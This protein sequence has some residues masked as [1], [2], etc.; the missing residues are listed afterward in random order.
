[1][2]II[3]N[4]IEVNVTRSEVSKEE[5]AG[6]LIHGTADSALEALAHDMSRSARFL[7][8]VKLCYIDPPFNTGEKFSHYHDRLSRSD[9]LEMMRATLNQIYGALSH[10]GSLWL[11]LDDSQQ[12]WGRILLDEVFGEESFV[13]TVIW[14]KRT[15]RDNRKAFSS[16]HDYIHVYA[17]NGPKQWKAIRNGVTDPGEF[18]NPDSDPRGPWR[19]APMTVQAG[20]ATSAQF[21]TLV[22]PAGVP[23]DPPPGRCWTYTENRLTEL[24]VQGRIYWP[25][26]GAGKPRLKIYQSES[27]GL[28][29]FTIWTSA[30]VGDS[31]SAKKAL[32][33]L[34]PDIPT[35]D[36]PKPERLLERIIAI[37]SDQNDLVLDCFLGSGTTAVMAQR[38]GR[39]WVGVEQNEKTIT[40]FVI[41]RIAR[42]DGGGFE[43]ISSDDHDLTKG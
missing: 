9:W 40:N 23:H 21:Y 13:A 35:F 33:A 22:S 14:Q 16:M 3:T 1:M 12:H 27:R 34:F 31:G 15:T 43:L 41:P 8:K 29:P 30:E 20:H 10:D 5:A 28:A 42:E 24:D 26:N 37:G 39:R 32:R 25:R 17:K 36:T 6:L 11:H 19:S 7:G 2:A 38:M 18:S 4:E